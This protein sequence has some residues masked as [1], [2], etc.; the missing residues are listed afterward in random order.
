M[1][2]IIINAEKHNAPFSFGF[3]STM[4]LFMSG[5]AKRQIGKNL[6]RCGSA[7]TRLLEPEATAFAFRTK[8]RPAPR[9]QGAG[10]VFVLP[11]AY[12]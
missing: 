4:L 11:T 6:V 9:C 10:E 1:L 2:W 5:N 12:T 7:P 3:V 8:E